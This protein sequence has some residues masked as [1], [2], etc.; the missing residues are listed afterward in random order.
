MT[1]H[2]FLEEGSLLAG[3][4]RLREL[5]AIIVQGRYDMVCPIVTAYALHRAW[6][7][8]EFVIVPDAGHSAM[9]TGTRA[10][11]VAATQRMKHRALF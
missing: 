11:L 2:M 5:P 10:Q 1:H 4:D 9:E 8:S 7:A 3:I 6:P